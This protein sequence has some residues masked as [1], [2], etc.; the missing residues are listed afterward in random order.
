LLKKL[1]SQDTCFLGIFS[2]H[3]EFSCVSIL[4][5]C[6]ERNPLRSLKNVFI[7]KIVCLHFDWNWVSVVCL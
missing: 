7:W 6:S 3:S 4:A 1:R 2:R 5:P